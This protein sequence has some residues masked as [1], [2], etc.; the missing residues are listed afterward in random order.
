MTPVSDADLERALRA[1]LG[2]TASFRPCQLESIRAALDGRDCLAVLPTGAGKSLAYMLPAAMRAARDEPGVIVVV[3]PLLSLIRDQIRRCDE[4]DVEAESWTSATEPARLRAVERDLRLSA[5]DGGPTRAC[6]S[7]TPES[8][9]ARLGSRN[10]ANAEPLETATSPGSRW[11]RR[12]ARRSG[13]T[14]SARRTSAFAISATTSRIAPTFR[15]RRSARLPRPRAPS[16]R[17]RRRSVFAT[18]ASFVRR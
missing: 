4:F 15:S 5:E 13:D 9:R 17:V 10:A 7:S 8:L 12:T 14:I 2:P 3:S 1:R 6:C 18:R 16:R 11:T